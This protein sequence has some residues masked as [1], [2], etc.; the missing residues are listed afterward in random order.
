MAGYARTFIRP[1]HAPVSKEPS[2]ASYPPKTGLPNPGLLPMVSPYQYQHTTLYSPM[3]LQTNNLDIINPSS[4]AQPPRHT[5]RNGEKPHTNHPQPQTPPHT[6]HSQYHEPPLPLQR[7]PILLLIFLPISPLLSVLYMALGHAILRQDLKSSNSIYHAPIISSIEAGATGGVILSLPIA[8]LLYLLIFPGR[9]PSVPE[10]FFED[11]DTVTT[12]SARWTM[13]AGYLICVFFF[14][15][16]GGVAG[17]LGV[18]CLSSGTSHAF[19]VLKKML[20]PAAAA[21]AGFVGGVVLSFGILL[22]GLLIV[23]LWSF[24]MRRHRPLSP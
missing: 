19:V 24:W 12:P 16:I 3:A 22:L 11:D 2:S 20:S 1:E 7:R 4:I 18:I 23:S 6:A 9:Q 8:L 21:A 14:F 10:D 5:N 13:Y 15:G 17:P